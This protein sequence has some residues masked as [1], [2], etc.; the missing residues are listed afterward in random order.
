[1]AF[2]KPETS[3][4]ARLLRRSDTAAEQRLWERLR[5][6]RLAGLKFVRQLPVGPYCADFACRER[7]VIVEVD[8]A[9]H[10]ERGEVA[11]DATRDAFLRHEGYA[12]LR[13]WNEDVFKNIDGVLESILIA[14][15][16][17]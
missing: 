13:M 6:R 10:G 7:K 16:K 14:A 11:H 3:R 8:G 15:G 9:T 4:R 2:Q 17:I 5:S 1:M 12:V